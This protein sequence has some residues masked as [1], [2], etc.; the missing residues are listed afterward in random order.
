MKECHQVGLKNDDPEDIKRRKELSNIVLSNSKAICKKKWKA[1][2]KA[3]L[4]L[5][6]S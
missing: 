4:H 6:E 3:R 1:Q 2:L 5:H